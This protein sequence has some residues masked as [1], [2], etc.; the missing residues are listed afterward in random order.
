[1]ANLVS[2][3][4]CKNDKVTKSCNSCM[5]GKKWDGKG[6]I[7]YM[8]YNNMQEISEEHSVSFPQSY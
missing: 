7:Q 2:I 5:Y 1:M 8:R 3:I 6:C 4:G